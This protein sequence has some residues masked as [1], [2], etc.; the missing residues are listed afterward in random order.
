MNSLPITESVAVV[1]AG[2]MGSGIVQVAATAG[3]PVI[4]FDVSEGAAERARMRILANLDKLVEKRRLDLE[5]R[6]AIASRIA[7]ADTLEGLAPARLIIEAIIEKLEPKQALFKGLEDLVSSEAIFA[8]NTSSISITAIA[9]AL[10][11]PERLAGMHF[12]N[13]A[14]IMK[15][16]EIV[17][18]VATRQDILQT[19]TDTASAWGKVAVQ[20]RST[21]GFIVNRVARPFYGE[22]LRPLE[23]GVTDTASIDA[24]IREAGAFRM[25][26]FELMDLIGNDVNFAVTSSIFQ[27]YFGDPRYRPS[28]IQQELVAAGWLGRKSGRGFYGYDQS[29]GVPEPSTLTGQAPPRQVSIEGSLGPAEPLAALFTKAGLSVS[30]KPGDG[31]IRIEGAT[32]ALSDGRTATARAC[33][34]NLKDLVL[35]DAALDFQAA[36]RIAIAVAD[37]ADRSALPAAAG[38][39][40]AAGKHVTE[41]DDTPSM[42]VLRTL[43]M[44]ANEAVEAVLQGVAS[45]GDVDRA[46][47]LGVNY[48]CGPIAWAD[49]FGSS[50]V[51]AVLDALQAECGDDRYRPSSLLK[52]CARAGRPLC[53]AHSGK[54]QSLPSDIPAN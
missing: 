37:Q 11:S 34:G 30:R 42:V 3:H 53:N 20:A 46:M 47:T 44:L 49:S 15:L 45:P 23:E 7:V 40:Q 6:E 12:F 22:A 17:T 36:P 14:P 24:L 9:S 52:R 32:L 35:F 51:M 31:L 28:L 16:V 43:S 27:S 4:I 48:P 19:L 29:S 33:D 1:G 25:G 5:Q 10:R 18:G 13:P 38:L 54:H 8:T 26:P 2:A 50:R 21:P 41:I 39:F